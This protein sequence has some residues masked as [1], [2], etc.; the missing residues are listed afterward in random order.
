MNEQSG[1][2]KRILPVIRKFALLKGNERVLIGLS[3]GPDSLCLLHLLHAISDTLGLHLH[4]LYVD[5]GLRPDEVPGEIEFC[6]RAC[7]DL[8]ID[9]T[10]R[11]V[12][13]KGDPSRADH[14]LQAAARELRYNALYD[15]ARSLNMAKIALGHTKSDNTETVLIN[16]LRGSGMKGLSGIPPSRGIIIRPLIETTREEV[17][18]FLRSRNIEYLTDPSNLQEKYLRNILRLRLIPEIVKINPDINETLYRTGEILRQED[19]YLELQVTKT[20]MRLFSRK[21]PTRIEL[22]LT[23]MESLPA[24]ILRRVL[25]RAVIEL[26]DISTLS[27]QHTEDIIRLIQTG[28]NGDRLE[29]PH[30]LRVIRRYSVMVFTTEPP[31]RLN[32]YTLHTDQELVIH[33]ASIVLKAR[34]THSPPQHDGKSTVVLDL[35]KV[36]LPLTVRKRRD[37][38]F[39]FPS[40][41][42]KK[43]KVQDFFVDEKVPRD[44][45]DLVPLICSGEDIVWIAG[46]RNDGRFDPDGNTTDFLVL[47][48]E[49]ARTQ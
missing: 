21:S 24:V 36:T 2:K 8:G 6:S 25:R 37:G 31:G 43:K 14:G 4:A 11:T 23:P 27:F 48:L 5:H 18:D 33:E 10:T 9:L 28:N 44:D 22:F 1:I 35:R 13:V 15:A 20:L 39:F 3:G 46:Y 17:L 7:D 26:K 42:G 38:D 12:D 49:H 30:D 32:E 29:L 19:E 16:L 45:R 41:F 47:T 40:G 34:K